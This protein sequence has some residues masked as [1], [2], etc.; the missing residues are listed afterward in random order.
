MHIISY[1]NC[2]AQDKDS[3][4]YNNFL[5]FTMPGQQSRK[6]RGLREDSFTLRYQV[7]YLLTIQM[8]FSNSFS[9][10]LSQ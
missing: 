6:T 8:Q 7:L 1:Y 10:E 4:I 9:F 2:G 5:P 3:Y